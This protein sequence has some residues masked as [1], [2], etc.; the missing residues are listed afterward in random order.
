MDAKIVKGRTTTDAAKRAE[1]DA[2]ILRALRDGELELQ[3]HLLNS[4]NN[5]FLARVRWARAEYFV[6][7]KPARGERPLWDFETGTLV[8]REV[9]AYI[10]SQMLGFPNIPPTVLREGPFGIG[11]VQLFIE[12]RA[13][14]NYFTLRAAQRAEM[15]RIAVFDAIVNNTD[16]KG[17][18]VLS[19]P[20][21]KIWA[22]DHGL[23]FHE[24]YKLRTVIWDFV[25]QAI[26]REILDRAR[27][28]RACLDQEDASARELEQLL[29]RRELRALRARTDDLIARGVYPDPP[30][31]WP[32]IPWPPV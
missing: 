21:G 29:T 14:E 1:S 27:A 13:A 16:R 32:H 18:H 19:D 10:V 5:A 12:F 20:A 9:A 15:K 26:P 31:D 7:Y 25:G 3:E 4:S 24:E 8:N 22:I 11:A 30:L 2:P 17:G 6:T 23:T 28:L